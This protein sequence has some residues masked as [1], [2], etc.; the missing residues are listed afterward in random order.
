VPLHDHVLQQAANAILSPPEGDTRP[1]LLFLAGCNGSG[2]TSF[3]EMLDEQP[4]RR[5]TFVNADLIGAVVAA[6]PAKDRLAQKIADL[7][8]HHMVEEHASFAT[9]TVFSDEV[10]AKLKFLRDAA[11]AGFHVVFVYVT[12]ANVHLSRQR[13]AYRVQH[14]GHPV[15]ED[16]LLRRFV[17]SRENCRR[18]LYV[19]ETGIVV[20]NSSA[21]H[22]LRLMAIVR[23]GEIAYQKPVLPAYVKELL[24]IAPARP[25]QAAGDSPAASQ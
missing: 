22:P 20:D 12:L 23:K 17:A 16:R 1:V 25:D 6:I 24:P 9:E 7:I 10:G 2:K 5:F 13:V 21:T 3:F 15:P 19:V 4:G 14:G 11:E 8:R 18:A